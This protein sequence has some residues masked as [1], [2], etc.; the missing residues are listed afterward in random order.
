MPGAPRAPGAPRRPPRPATP[1]TLLR[2]AATRAAH[3]PFFVAWALETYR[4]G[5]GL[6][7]RTL[8]WGLGVAA[9]ALPKLALCRR[10]ASADATFAAD[11]QQIAT[12][13]G[14]DVDHLANVLR[15]AESVEALRRVQPG[16]VAGGALLAARDAAPETS[17]EPQLGTG[18]GSG[19]GTSVDAQPAPRGDESD[20]SSHA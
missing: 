8:A 15:Y 1:A 17:A 16:G 12:W 11:V 18:G 9:A 5:E 10:P 2:H 13:A 6:D 3:D 7:E 14:V 19:A 4:A 20:E